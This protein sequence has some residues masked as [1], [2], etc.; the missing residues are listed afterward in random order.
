[1]AIVD[2]R[3]AEVDAG[4]LPRICMQCGGP[5]TSERLKRFSRSPAWVAFLHPV[6]LHWFFGLAVTKRV[7]V[8]A[9]FCERHHNHWNWRAQC[10]TLALA[11]YLLGA[12][13]LLGLSDLLAHAQVS[14]DYS[15][16]VCIGAV[17]MT[18]TVVLVIKLVH[19]TGIRALEI[20]ERMI[21]LTNVA[22]EFTDAVAGR[23]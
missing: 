7:D 19:G 18:A 10:A 6:G 22:Q 16:L 2:L 15:G 17:A 3:I 21:R 8:Y 9:P 20:S 23:R 5:A 13:L 1:M 4:R 12:I 14:H 11:F